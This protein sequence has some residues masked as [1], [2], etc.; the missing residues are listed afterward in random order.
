M[1]GA[2][3]PVGAMSS[4]LLRE[5]LQDTLGEGYRLER[6]LGGGGMSRVFLAAE[7]AL[8]RRVVVKVLPPD[9]AAAVNVERFRREIQLAA[10]LQHPH[11]VPLLSAGESGGV[12]YYTMPFVDGE[13]LRVRLAREGALSIDQAVRVVRDIAD[14][15]AY[16]H[17]CGVVHRD[18]KPDNVL[19]SRGHALVADFGVAKALA[20]AATSPASVTATSVTVEGL[21]VV[22]RTSAF[23]FKGK[24]VGLREV[25][26]RLN[27]G[28][29]L[30]GS[31][32]RAGDRLR[33]SAQL[34]D[35]T[36]DATLWSE[37][38]DG[39]VQDVFA[40][41]EGIA[42]A[43]VGA[44]RVRLTGRTAGDIVRQPT[45]NLEAYELYLTGRYAWNQRTARSIEDAI[46]YFERAIDKDSTFALAYAGLADAYAILPTYAFTPP[47]QASR[48]AKAAA[49]RALEL[50]SSLAEAYA[51]LGL[52]GADEYDWA[53]AED[54][55]KRAIAANPRYATAHHWYAL[56]LWC[57]GRLPDARVAAERAVALDP[58]SRVIGLLPGIERYYERDYDGAVARYRRILAA[59]PNY[60]GAR[61][62]LALALA[63]QGKAAE[64]MAEARES[65]RLQGWRPTVLGGYLAYIRARAGDR[66]KAQRELEDLL[67]RSRTEYVPETYVA[68]VYAALGDS[69]RAFVWL[70]KA[71]DVNAP[72]VQFIKVDPR[73]D[74]VRSDRRFT[75]VLKKMRLEP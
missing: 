35:V 18:V 24:T 58:S 64:A 20:A 3:R 75:L 43:I 21:R 11:I 45:G 25:G 52:V 17:E 72:E 69:D 49:L 60:G 40:V 13:S 10:R 46:S 4:E 70:E 37:A 22:S 6:E 59:D 14:A 2:G 54:A 56:A 44:L 5:Q 30:Q 50:D 28:T 16:A 55:Y 73:F 7:T 65:G 36:G 67:H 61:Q 63:Q 12:L 29:V 34:V 62:Y 38:Y 68:A 41:Q 8:G 47:G 31:V 33:V 51:T 19:L 27:V 39:A 66:A 26:D 15:L 71:V 9:V 53:G 48:Q 74:P 42:R 57:M 1:F 32:R 23:A